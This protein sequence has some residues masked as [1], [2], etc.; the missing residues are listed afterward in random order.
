ML[1]DLRG[2]TVGIP[3]RGVQVLRVSTQLL[4]AAN[5]DERDLAYDVPQAI[6]DLVLGD[7]G[8]YPP[9][10]QSRLP[11]AGY[12]SAAKACSDPSWN[13]WS[14]STANLLESI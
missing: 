2:V 9:A 10:M 7:E 12:R 11:S 5:I 1:I 13:C 14:H 6:K 4:T 8:S 3:S